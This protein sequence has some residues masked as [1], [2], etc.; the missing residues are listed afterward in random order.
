[1]DTL[2]SDKINMLLKK[3]VWDYD[4]PTERLVAIF[5]GRESTFS[6]TANK[7][8]MR[9]LMSTAWYT[10]IDVFGIQTL[11]EFLSDDVLEG[12]HIPD[13]REKFRNARTILDAC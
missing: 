10:L 3:S 5:E 12:I 9:L 4:I 8:R 7:L 11:K 1:M 2:K 13:V 6:L